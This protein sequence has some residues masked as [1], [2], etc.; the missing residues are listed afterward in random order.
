MLY[1]TAQF[2]WL[3]WL[4]NLCYTGIQ[5]IHDHVHHPSCLAALCRVLVDWIRLYLQHWAETIHV[6]MTVLPQLSCKLECQ[7]LVQVGRKV[8]EGIS[9]GKL[10]G[11]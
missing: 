2:V 9:Q 5:V 11:V 7:H 3:K 4:R 10:G 6:D 1:C 8:A